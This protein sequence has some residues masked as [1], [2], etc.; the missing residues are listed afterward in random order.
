MRIFISHSSRDEDTARLLINLLQNALQ[1]LNK[2]DILCTS[3]EGLG[4]PVGNDPDATIRNAIKEAD[5]LIGLITPN[6]IK[7]TYVLFELGGRWLIDKPMFPLL[8]C[9]AGLED[10]HGPLTRIQILDCANEPNVQDFIRRAADVLNLTAASPATYHHEIREFI[11]AALNTQQKEPPSSID[12]SL[13]L[14]PAYDLSPL[15][16]QLLVDA[17]TPGGPNTGQITI[18]RTIAHTVI[19]TDI[20]SQEM[21]NEN[22]TATSMWQTAIE[23]LTTNQLVTATPSPPV[24]GPRI[25]TYALTQKGFEFAHVLRPTM[26]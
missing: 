22:P 12:P 9:G 1:N 8:A 24:L 7:S 5:L 20:R 18:S 19:T 16:K 6:A 11:D 10:L 21:H 4:L 25:R 23:E 14:H 17:S 13:Q 15:T 3:V 2:D 26:Q